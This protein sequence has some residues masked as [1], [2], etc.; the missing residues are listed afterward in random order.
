MAIAR[1]RA[2]DASLSRTKL[3]SEH[4]LPWKMP[5]FSL[6]KGRHATTRVSKSLPSSLKSA[7]LFRRVTSN[8]TMLY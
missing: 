2:M 5:A 1:L 4:R 6:V 3:L 7:Q 8:T